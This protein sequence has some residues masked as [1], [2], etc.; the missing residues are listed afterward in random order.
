MFHKGI[1]H[2]FGA[3][4]FWGL[5]PIYWKLLKPIPATQ[6]IGHRIVWSFLLLVLILSV[7]RKWPELRA[8]LSDRKILLIYSVAAILCGINWFIYVWAVTSG[9]I[10]EASLGYFINPL[11]SV[12]LGVLLLRERLRRIQWASIGLASIGVIYLTLIYGRL[13]WIALSLAVTFGFY[14]LVKKFAPLKS[15]NGL[16]LETGILF[17]PGL[18][19]LAYQDHLGRG[20]FLH[21]GLESDLLMAGAGFI[22]TVPASSVCLRRSAHIANNH[23]H[24]AIHHA[25]SSIPARR[26]DL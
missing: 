25:D 11:L 12:L 14:G 26:S 10:V 4:F 22:T 8:P 6:L 5:V 13:P 1:W 18:L 7:T 20:A 3:Y 19:F 2:A 23:R 9:H 21:H 15:A 17:V 24:H 16:T